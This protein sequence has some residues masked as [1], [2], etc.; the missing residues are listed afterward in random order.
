MTIEGWVAVS[1]ALVVALG[2]LF[3]LDGRVTTH[4]KS[5]EIRQAAIERELRGIH[6]RFDRLDDKLDRALER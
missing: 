3:R 5:C 4:E 6:E 2:W 1:S